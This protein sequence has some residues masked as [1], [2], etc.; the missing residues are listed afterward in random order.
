MLKPVPATWPQ[1]NRERYLGISV[2]LTNPENVVHFRLDSDEALDA[3]LNA[4]NADAES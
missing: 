2:G 3:L 1:H 4:G